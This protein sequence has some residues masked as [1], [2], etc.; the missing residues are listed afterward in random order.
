MRVETNMERGLI[1][2]LSSGNFRISITGAPSNKSRGIFLLQSESFI[3]DR[4]GCKKETYST[5]ASSGAYL[6]C[7]FISL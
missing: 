6:Y 5:P 1:N 3:L 7:L 4:A 2:R